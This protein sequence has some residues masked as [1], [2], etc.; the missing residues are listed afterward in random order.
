MIWDVW[1]PELTPVEIA[2][3]TYLFPRIEA[4]VTAP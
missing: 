1:H 3:M 2:S 4:F